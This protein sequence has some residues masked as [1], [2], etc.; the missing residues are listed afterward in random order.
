MTLQGLTGVFA[1]VSLVMG[2]VWAQGGGPP[3]SCG[4]GSYIQVSGEW[5]CQNGDEVVG[6]ATQ[7]D[8]A[9]IEK[10]VMPPTGHW[11]VNGRLLPGT[12]EEA[13]L[14][15][16]QKINGD[17]G[18]LLFSATDQFIGLGTVDKDSGEFEVFTRITSDG[19]VVGGL[20][21]EVTPEIE[22]WAQVEV[23]AASGVLRPLVRWN[24]FWEPSKIIEVELR[25]FTLE[26]P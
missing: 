9:L 26:F 20:E 2:Q 3:L 5:D 15:F 13:A 24:T 25:R 19:T 4:D 7:E 22:V 1:V 11:R 8:F 12:W 14:I 18:V 10:Q 17:Y 6:T 21:R 23:D 16:A